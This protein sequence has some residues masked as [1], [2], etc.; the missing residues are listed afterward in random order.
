MHPKHRSPLFW[1]DTL[2]IPVGDA[3]REVRLMAIN[4]MASIY[5]TAVQVLVLDAEL[6]QC[7]MNTSTA[8]ET[9][10]RIACSAWMTRS[11]TL[12]EGVLASE[13]VFQFKDRAIDP[14]HEWCH[15]GARSD[16]R[17]EA[18]AEAFPSGD[19]EGAW[20][21]YKDLYDHFWDTLR[22]DWKSTFRRD[23]PTEEAYTADGGDILRMGKFRGS[24]A[25]GKVHMLPAA[26]RGCEKRNTSG[27][28]KEDH[29]TLDFGKYRRLKQLIDMWNELAHRSITMPDDLHVI[30]ANLLDFN[31]DTIM[32]LPSRESRMRAMLLSFKTLPVSLFWNTGPRWK[33]QD[34]DCNQWIPIE[35]SKSALTMTPVME[36]KEG[37]L[38][39]DFNTRVEDEVHK[40]QILS[41][42]RADIA[43]SEKIR[44]VGPLHRCRI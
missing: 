43:L 6:L 35:P 5:A 25:V 14:V 33:D 39:L 29:F 40:A 28:D 11:W 2:C 12:Q 7:E 44:G 34:N 10:A 16:D 37:W 15:H 24:Q 38:R 22:N 36:V 20:T 18:C 42:D 19:D 21:V 4:Q 8:T 23:P 32:A 27:L 30:I 41:F 9:L 26:A 3:E 1:M 17:T 31:A 13:C